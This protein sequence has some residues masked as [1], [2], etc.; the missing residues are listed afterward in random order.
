MTKLEELK[1]AWDAAAADETD[2]AVA[3]QDANDAAEGAS[4]AA[5]TAYAAHSAAARA[6]YVAYSAYQIELRKQENNN[7]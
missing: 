4:D 2:A 6:E 3:Y 7:A 1:A 5:Y